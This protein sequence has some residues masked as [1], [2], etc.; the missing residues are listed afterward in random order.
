MERD[1]GAMSHDLRECLSAES[2]AVPR[3]S[4]SGSA[5]DDRKR[6][7]SSEIMGRKSD[8]RVGAGHGRDGDKGLSHLGGKLPGLFTWTWASQVVDLR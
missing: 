2:V 7:D 1:R 8:F 3:E 5:A 6:V 4:A